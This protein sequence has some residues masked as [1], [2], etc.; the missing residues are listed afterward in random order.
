[1]YKWAGL[2]EVPARVSLWVKENTKLQDCADDRNSSN[3]TGDDNIEAHILDGA[4]EA[5]NVTPSGN[6]KPKETASGVHVSRVC[7]R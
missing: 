3:H 7:R 5:P 6:A 4:G 1:M 2:G